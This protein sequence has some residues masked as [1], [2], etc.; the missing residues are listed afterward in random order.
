M[1]S[2][3]N[4]FLNIL[5]WFNILSWP[6]ELYSQFRDW[7]TVRKTCKELITQ[8]LFKSQKPE[9]RFDRIYRLYTVANIPEELYPKEY[10]N[11]RQTYL[12]DQLRKME[13]VTLRLGISEILY[14]EFV[15]ITDVP[16]SFAYLLVL[17]TNKDA[18]SWSNLLI[19]VLQLM[20]FGAMLLIVNGIFSS[21]VGTGIIDWF[22]SILPF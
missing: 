9:I 2:K 20:S 1:A 18:Y 3:D 14:P 4:Y 17:E 22:L 5:R 7:N 16:D 21:I 15:V 6:K 12:I 8:Q 10:E 19:W 13:E 11:A